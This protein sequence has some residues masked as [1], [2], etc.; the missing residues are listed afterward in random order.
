MIMTLAL[1]YGKTIIVAMARDMAPIVNAC[2]KTTREGGRRR[3][4]EKVMVVVGECFVAY[5]VQF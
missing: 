2:A 1:M 3:K 5:P 4:G